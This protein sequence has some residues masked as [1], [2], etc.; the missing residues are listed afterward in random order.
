MACHAFHGGQIV[1]HRVWRTNRLPKFHQILPSYFYISF[2]H[3]EITHEVSCSLRFLISSFHC[4]ITH[5]VVSCANHAEAKRIFK[6]S[7][8]P[9]IFFVLISYSNSPHMLWCVEVLVSFSVRVLLIVSKDMNSCR[10]CCRSSLAITITCQELDRSPASN[11]Q[12]CDLNDHH[13]LSP[14]FLHIVSSTFWLVIFLVFQECSTH[15]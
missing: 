11:N 1:R 13:L 12:N 15:V 7:Q 6:V 10:H 5:V 2:L 3:W 9:I 4:E 8:Q 14:W